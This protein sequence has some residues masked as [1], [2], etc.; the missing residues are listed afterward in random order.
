MDRRNSWN[1]PARRRGSQLMSQGRQRRDRDL[2]S[3]PN[4][5]AVGN[6][7]QAAVVETDRFGCSSLPAGD[8]GTSFCSTG[9]PRIRNTPTFGVVAHKNKSSQT[10]GGQRRR[11]VRTQNKW[12]RLLLRGQLPT[13]ALLMNRSASRQATAGHLAGPE[14]S[15]DIADILH[16]P[17]KVVRVGAGQLQKAASE[18]TSFPTAQR[19]SGHS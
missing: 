12:Q 9:H 15:K 18:R 14:S 13:C 1:V 16:R 10:Y 3:V 8:S 11:R 5:E 17:V 2:S 7:L 4:V 19:V 6:H